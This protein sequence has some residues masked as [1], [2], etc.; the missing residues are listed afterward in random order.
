MMASDSYVAVISETAGSVGAAPGRLKERLEYAASQGYS[1][2]LFDYVFT[3]SQQQLRHPRHLFIQLKSKLRETKNDAEDVAPAPKSSRATL[4]DRAKIFH[5]FA[6]SA[7][8]KIET[9]T[10]SMPRTPK[11]ARNNSK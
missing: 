9:S 10:R 7:T 6:T 2:L 11:D 5:R 8:Q 1:R 4:N 3:F